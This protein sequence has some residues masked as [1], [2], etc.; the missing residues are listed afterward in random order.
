[1]LLEWRH[2]WGLQW[3]ICQ[4]MAMSPTATRGHCVDTLQ[5][6]MEPGRQKTKQKTK[7]P[8]H[9][10]KYPQP[11]DGRSFLISNRINMQVN[12]IFHLDSNRRKAL[13]PSILN[14]CGEAEEHANTAAFDVLAHDVHSDS[15]WEALFMLLQDCCRFL[16]S[17]GCEV[18]I[19]EI[20]TKYGAGRAR[21]SE[22]GWW[23]T[24]S[25]AMLIFLEQIVRKT[26]RWPITCQQRD[27][28]N[29]VITQISVTQ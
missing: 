9:L 28:E 19:R 2:V 26:K 24:K 14:V 4:R 1:M 18:K 22:G 21:G 16:R 12:F 25:N 5:P 27:K 17:G 8:P 7:T 29:R 20:E 6:A 10:L 23:N 13:Q 3:M 15:T 11:G